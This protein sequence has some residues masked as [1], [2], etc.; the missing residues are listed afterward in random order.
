MNTGL[1]SNQMSQRRLTRREL[2]KL[3]AGLAA[4]A[5]LP[6]AHRAVFARGLE[7]LAQGAPRVLWLQ[8]QACSG[9][10]VSL[11]N[12]EEDILRAI[13][14]RIRL[15]FHTVLFAAQ[16]K[17][18]LELIEKAQG[19][20]EPL[21]LVFEG[22]LPGAMP[23][24]CTIGG[25]SLSEILLPVLKR[26]QF[27]VA[28]GT[29]ASFGGIP[30]AEGNPTGAI[31]LREAM[32]EAQIPWEGRLVHCPG[33][34]AHPGELLGTLVHLA[35]QGYPEVK[36]G[37]L[38]PKMFSSACLHDQCPMLSQH[39]AGVFAMQFGDRD[40][41]LYQ[42]GCRGLDVTADC[43]RRGWNGGVNWCVQAGAPCI[44]CNQPSFA[45]SRS[46]AFYTKSKF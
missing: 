33:C 43:P 19:S 25:R 35:G 9:C 12:A 39:H 27:I 30:S 40:C 4:V 16:G 13:T 15:A 31:S 28:A 2:L 29:C 37:S 44:G 42:L 22:A 11:L 46:L 6:E 20:D 32:L 5:G 34:P 18:A 10:S 8:G 14:E 1:K 24:A 38:I 17:L 41:C 7:Q 36:A 3:G 45:K 21:I 23:Q 26:A